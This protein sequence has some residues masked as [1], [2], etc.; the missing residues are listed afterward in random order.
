MFQKSGENV[1][2]LKTKLAE[3]RHS[4][5]SENLPFM[6]GVTGLIPNIANSNNKSDHNIQYTY[7]YPTVTSEYNLLA[8]SQDKTFQS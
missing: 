5:T 7:C 6:S 2:I 8:S 1:T 4:S 3:L